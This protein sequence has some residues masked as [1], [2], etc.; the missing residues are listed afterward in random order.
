MKHEMKLFVMKQVLAE[1]N[2]SGVGQLVATTGKA[3]LKDRI[4]N[5]AKWSGKKVLKLTKKMLGLLLGVIFHLLFLLLGAVIVIIIPILLVTAFLVCVVVVA[6]MLAGVFVSSADATKDDF[7]VTV[8][9][10]YQSE[11]LEEAEKYVGTTYKGKNVEQ[12]RIIYDGINS[13][14]DNSDDLLLA[15]FIK[16]TNENKFEEDASQAPLL[17]VNTIKEKKAMKEVLTGMLYKKQV[18]YIRKSR[19]VN[20][21]VSPTEVVEKKESYYVVDIVVSGKSV[22]EWSIKHFSDKEKDLY[23]FFLEMF[24]SFGYVEKGGDH[25]CTKYQ[26]ALLE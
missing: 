17:N 16:A 5:A 22:E 13:I 7:A 2:D 26:K 10:N 23:D 11:L 1:G 21:A 24:Q 6:A 20:V 8:I 3:F 12:V 9:R 19:T 18:N 25:V 14:D 4:K 15:Y